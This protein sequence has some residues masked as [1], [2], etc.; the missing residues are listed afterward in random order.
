MEGPKNYA[1]NCYKLLRHHIRLIIVNLAMSSNF[2]FGFRPLVSALFTPTHWSPTE[3]LSF[4][5]SPISGMYVASSRFWLRTFL[6]S[7]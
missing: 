3:G 4:L 6:S 5:I 1:E 7:A 2:G